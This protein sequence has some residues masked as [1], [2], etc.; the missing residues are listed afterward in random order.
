MFLRRRL[1]TRLLLLDQPVM[2]RPDHEVEAEA[3]KNYRW[4]FAANLLDGFAFFFGIA[5]ASSSTIVPLFVSKMTFNPL[6]I[7]LVAMIAQA[8]WFLPQLL[9]AGRI[10]RLAR[11]KPVVIN[12]GFFTER[13]PV[14][15]WP[16]A[17]WIAVDHPGLALWLFIVTYAWH[18]LGAGIVGPAWQDLLARCFPVH[19][20]G[21]IFGLTTF[22]GTAAATV[23]AGLSSWILFEYPYPTNFVLLFSIAAVAIILS[24]GFLAL[25][26]EPVQTAPHHAHTTTPMWRRMR[27]ILAED[28]NFRAYLL[29]RMLLILGAMGTGFIT[30][31]SIERWA[32][33][34]AVVGIYTA[35]LLLGQTVGNLL[36]GLIADR[37]GHKLPLLWGGITQVAAF[38]VAW[39]TPSPLGMY[40]VFALIGFATG[41]NLVSGTLIALEF[42]EPARRPTYIGIA[43]TAIGVA[44]ALAPLIGGWVAGFGYTWLFGLS[45]LIGA[46][47]LVQLLRTVKDPR[48]SLLQ[49]Q[50]AHPAEAGG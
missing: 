40:G 48:R 24:W 35:I 10:E 16:V 38:A 49:E 33:P 46:A 14:L 11:K 20:R 5:F 37:R 29:A 41:V 6:I 3:E 39:V 15:L 43:N 47:A 19:K 31:I 26:R 8:G 25:V 28:H 22:S 45:T 36:A 9:S 21:L 34:D 44:S 4:N 32:V 2:E 17:A 18:G 42:S 7:G 13:L 12:L 27:A 1:L 23:G 30:V 50:L